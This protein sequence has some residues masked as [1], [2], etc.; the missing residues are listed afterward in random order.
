MTN[1]ASA[2]TNLTGI[3]I[4]DPLPAGVSYV[5]GSS[6]VTGW[7]TTTQTDNVRDNFDSQAYN[8]N[9]GTVNWFGSWVETD[10]TGGSQRATAGN[11]QILTTGTRQLRFGP[12]SSIYRQVDLSSATSATLTLDYTTSQP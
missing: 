8:L 10:P 11:V 4:Y 2:T 9:D 5:A 6:Q 3:S 7:L 1:P 12:A